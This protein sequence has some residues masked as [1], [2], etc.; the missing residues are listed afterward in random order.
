M[1]GHIFV[2]ISIINMSLYAPVIAQC[3][4]IPDKVL[5]ATTSQSVV[6]KA[7]SVLAQ[8]DNSSAEY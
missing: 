5:K 1:G 3:T 8:N 7:I 6:I 2:S 4:K